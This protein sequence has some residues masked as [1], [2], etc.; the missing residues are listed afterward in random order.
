MRKERTE[1]GSRAH[2]FLGALLVP[3]TVLGEQSPTNV[4]TWS[5]TDNSL[6]YEKSA[7]WECGYCLRGIASVKLRN[8]E[9]QSGSRSH[10]LNTAKMDERILLSS[11][12]AERPFAHLIN[13]QFAHDDVVHCCGHFL[14]SVVVPSCMENTVDAT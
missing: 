14:P 1:G 12:S 5:F 4:G 13:P 6:W 2:H 9:W 11:R 10:I 7:V 3:D 8:Q